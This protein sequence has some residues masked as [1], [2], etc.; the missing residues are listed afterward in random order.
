M[1]NG[2]EEMFYLSNPEK[3]GYAQ[4]LTD[5]CSDELEHIVGRF[6]KRSQWSGQMRG[7]VVMYM[8]GKVEIRTSFGNKL[9]WTKE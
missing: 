8:D 9:L 3:V 4:D 1:K 5:L 7:K 2:I 6:T